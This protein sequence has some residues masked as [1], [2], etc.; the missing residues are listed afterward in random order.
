MCITHNHPSCLTRST[1]ALTLSFQAAGQSMIANV[2][3][4]RTPANKK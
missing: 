2:K 4:P 1:L 3:L